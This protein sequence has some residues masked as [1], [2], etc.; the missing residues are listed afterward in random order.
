MRGADVNIFVTG[1]NN[2]VRAKRLIGKKFSDPVVQDDILLWSFKVSQ[3]TK[4]KELCKGINPDE[5]VAYGA[6]VQAALLSEGIQNVPNDRKF[7]ET[8]CI[9]VNK[10]KAYITTKDNQT[11]S[12]IHVYGGERTRASDNNLL[13]SFILSGIPPAP[14]GSP[15]SNV[16]FSIDENGI[17]TVS[18]KNIASGS[19]N[20][21]TIT[22]HKER[23]SSEDIKKLIQ[24]AENYCIEDKKFLRKAKPWNALDDYIYKIRNALKKED[25]NL[26]L[27]SEEIE[28]IESAIAVATNLVD[29]KNQQVEIDVLEDHVKELQS[30]MKQIIAKTT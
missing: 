20:K 22:N 18:A 15:F 2:T 21:I 10:T 27:S 7:N 24:E 6:A 29:Q 25:I 23:L 9:P 3:C 8:L 4:D 16:C 26:K 19:S 5:V 17:L 12:S 30:W 11:I 14:R 13:G 1:K 28:K